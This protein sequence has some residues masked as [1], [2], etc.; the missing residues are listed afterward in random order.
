ML[1][2]Q[3]LDTLP[4]PL[5]IENEP[6]GEIDVAIADPEGF[7]IALSQLLN[8]LAPYVLQ[9]TL[10]NLKT[11]P[12]LVLA[13][14]LAPLGLKMIIDEATL[15]VLIFIDPGLKPVKTI[16]VNQTATPTKEFTLDP[17]NLSFYLN[18]SLTQT[19]N[20]ATGTPEI[21]QS[22]PVSGTLKP[23]LSVFGISLA[24]DISFSTDDPGIFSL[25]RIAAQYDFESPGLR[26]TAGNLT[27][28]V[29]RQQTNPA[30]VGITIAN[31]PQIEK[32]FRT[33]YIQELFLEESATVE[34]LLN[35]QL[36][37]IF[38]LPSGRYRFQDFSIQQGINTL[39]LNIAPLHETLPGSTKLLNT[40]EEPGN[41]TSPE[42]GSAYSSQTTFGYDLSTL[43][44][45]E[46]QFS[47]GIGYSSWDISGSP[48]P[49]LFG[50]QT[51]GITDTLTA[52]FGFHLEET[53]QF[54][55]LEALAA[56][57]FG[58]FGFSNAF[59]NT[60]GTGFGTSLIFDYTFL[61]AN[62]PRF[63]VSGSYIS[64]S[65]LPKVSDLTVSSQPVLSLTASA[66]HQFWNTLGLSGTFTLLA[67]RTTLDPGYRAD[68]QASLKITD[69]LLVSGSLSRS[70]I[71]GLQ[72]TLG[73]ILVTYHPDVHQ[74]L[75]TASTVNDGDT[76]LNYSLTPKSWN[77]LGNIRA[78]V[79]GLSPAEPLPSNVSL[80]GNLSNQYFDF[81]LSQQAAFGT[82]IT[83]PAL[84]TTSFTVASA[85]SYADGLFG[86]SKP[87]TDS[88]VIVGPKYPSDGLVFGVRTSEAT[89]NSSKNLF[90]TVVV[91]NI[92]A[93]SSNRLQVEIIDLPSGFDP[94]QTQALFKASSGQ[95][96]AF[97]IGKEAIVYASG[98]LL[99]ADDK[100]ASFV[101]GSV[102]PKTQPGQEPQDPQIIFTDNTG[103]FYIYDLVPGTY[104]LQFDL[105]GFSPYELVI[106]PQSSGFLDLGVIRLSGTQ[107]DLE[108]PQLL[109]DSFASNGFGEP[110]DAERESETAPVIA[111]AVDADA[112]EFSTA[113]ALDA[114]EPQV[115][116]LPA[117]SNPAA[118]SESLP[119]IA[120][121]NAPAGIESGTGSAAPQVSEPVLPAET[122][123][124]PEILP[125]NPVEAPSELPEPG[126]Q[127][128]PDPKPEPELA[129]PTILPAVSEGEQVPAESETLL[130][131]AEESTSDTED[132]IPEQESQEKPAITL[133]INPL[134]LA[135]VPLKTFTLRLYRKVGAELTASAVQGDTSSASLPDAGSLISE[136]PAS[137]VEK[138][139]GNAPR[140]QPYPNVQGRIKHVNPEAAL[141]DNSWVS[142]YFK[143]KSDGSFAFKELSPGDYVIS[144]FTSR[145]YTFPL[146][147]SSQD[148][149]DREVAFTIE[150]NGSEN[151]MQGQVVEIQQTP[152]N[153]KSEVQAV[154]EG[155]QEGTAVGGLPRSG[156]S[157]RLIPVDT[158]EA[159]SHLFR[160]YQFLTN[161]RITVE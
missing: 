90:G 67:E 47:Y 73:R 74:T 130:S 79:S 2:A 7:K 59:A 95:G 111:T 101:I 15:N 12:P 124:I 18:L 88:F 53:Y 43:A 38:T 150:E 27:N 119:A 21:F 100:P 26:L 86:L 13:K 44:K 152:E 64:D 24:S 112:G 156:Q 151:L 3:V 63:S 69:S 106:D 131:E 122:Q 128:E 153:Q 120:L 107:A 33:T 40:T 118:T 49:I 25:N 32:P 91:P 126:P 11:L 57:R 23:A 56:T 161:T 36:G 143:T 155:D 96:A 146:S 139:S 45:A 10:D 52:G 99:F 93:S 9:K 42:Q 37:R 72:Q 140:L 39:T 20:L 16:Q 158:L 125:E 87:I 84:F 97:R 113:M 144:F 50:A 41:E 75:T 134:Q 116:E 78:S 154:K 145:D 55:A 71:G 65:Y 29:V 30:A 83:D 109:T 61:Q 58:T 46:T 51:L 103:L 85:I 70:S 80:Y 147:I 76:S 135:E 94:G 89:F 141:A 35:N 31:I 132:V 5:F 136:T 129:V 81:G 108:T 92:S 17:A 123:P 48:A 115:I 160:W 6:A 148:P 60:P 82:E 157:S 104:E 117:D 1:S 149:Q 77:G 22:A 137:S 105:P 34:F 62:R 133:D 19:L 110:A 102:T 138:S 121:A 68:L 159:G 4:F 66:G 14:D 8:P 54:A 98:R 127:S 28:K 114:E 142:F